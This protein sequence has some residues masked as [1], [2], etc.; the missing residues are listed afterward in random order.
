MCAHREGPVSASDTLHQARLARGAGDVS[1]CLLLSAAA[2]Q[3]ARDERDHD[4]AFLAACMPGK[5]FAFRGEAGES[6]GY[7]RMALQ[8][9]LDKGLTQRLPEIYHDLF[10]SS[11]D[12]END[13]KARKFYG[14]ALRLYLDINPGNRRITALV[15]D[16]AESRFM[17]EPSTENAADAMQAWRGVPASLKGAQ[18]RFLSGCSLATSAAW[19]GIECRYEDGLS[20]MEEAFP[21]LPNYEGVALGFAHA[22]TGALRMREYPRALSLA[23]RAVSID[24]ARG[25][26]VAAARAEEVRIAALAER[27][28]VAYL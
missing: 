23:D 14:C 25:E 3:E 16:E 21:D 18:E 11:R 1:R 13:E 26:V 12:A 9:A 8:V 5:L 19:L 7:L 28:T 22:A 4:T 2:T 27:Q 15:A 6:L 24:T 10:I 17:R 20:A